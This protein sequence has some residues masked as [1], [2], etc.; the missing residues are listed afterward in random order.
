[1]KVAE[2]MEQLGRLDADLDVVCYTEDEAVMS[3]GISLFEIIEA[4]A[5]E[6]RT[7][8]GDD[9]VVHASFEGGSESSN[10]A[11][12]EITCDF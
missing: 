7:F 12:I 9:G 4:E 2:L 6:C 10:L 3:Q 8:R 1:M 11:I 5:K